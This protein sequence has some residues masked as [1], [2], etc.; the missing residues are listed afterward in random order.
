MFPVS[1]SMLRDRDAYD[2]S[3]EAFSRTLMPLV[4]YSLDDEGRMTVQNA[5]ACWKTLHRLQ[6]QAV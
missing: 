3:L 1:A 5:T 6:S 4:E 2:A